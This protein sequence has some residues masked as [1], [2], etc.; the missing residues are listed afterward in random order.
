MMVW[1]VVAALAVVGLAIVAH[2]LYELPLWVP[3]NNTMQ[4]TSFS[5]TPLAYA[6]TAPQKLAAD[7]GR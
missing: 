1:F 6:N 2:D 7:R 4:P 5:V 3:S